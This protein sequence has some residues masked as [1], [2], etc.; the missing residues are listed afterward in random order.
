MVVGFALSGVVLDLQIAQVLHQGITEGEGRPSE[1]L[2]KD[3]RRITELAPINMGV[4]TVGEAVALKT[5][6]AILLGNDV[7]PLAGVEERPEA[8]GMVDM[9]MRIDNC[10]QRGRAPGAN[11]LIDG[12]AVA[13]KARVDEQEAS[14]CPQRIG[15]DERCVQQ[16]V[17]C[18][19]M[20]R[21]K[22]LW[23]RLL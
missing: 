6:R 10:M 16:Q 3:Q 21:S 18:H 14:S 23:C 1:L 8:K 7:G 19:F 5:F 15:V 17:R 4:Q 2:G 20:R 13:R 11:S 12:L 22:E 9:A